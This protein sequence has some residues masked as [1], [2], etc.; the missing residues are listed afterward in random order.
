VTARQAGPA[1]LVVVVNGEE[2]PLV[3]SPEVWRRI[4]GDRRTTEAI[5][6][7]CQNGLVPCLPRPVGSG[8]HHRVAVAKALEALGI[9]FEIRAPAS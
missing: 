5:R 3:A 6:A 2:L 8:G 7:D 4:I 9:P 1:G